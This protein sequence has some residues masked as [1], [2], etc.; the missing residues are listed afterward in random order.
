MATDLEKEIR[1]VLALTDPGAFPEGT[2]VFRMIA[3]WNKE[4]ADAIEAATDTLVEGDADQF[5]DPLVATL[6]KAFDEL[7]VP[8]DIPGIPELIERQLEAFV[9]GYIPMAV[10]EVVERIKA[11]FAPEPERLP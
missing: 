7:V 4:I 3:V 8:Q 1:D 10:D 5:R 9:R 11:R 2:P 6:E